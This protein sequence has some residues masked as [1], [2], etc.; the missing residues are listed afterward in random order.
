MSRMCLA[1]QTAV[2][3]F[4]KF[5]EK[6]RDFLHSFSKKKYMVCGAGPIGNKNKNNQITFLTVHT[7]FSLSLR[8]LSK[9]SFSFLFSFFFLKFF[10]LLFIKSLC[11]WGKS[12]SSYKTS[13]HLKI[14][15][16]SAMM[17]KA[18]Q[19]C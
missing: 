10:L 15:S 13:Y 9:E 12:H 8:Y 14:A 7:N 3:Q 1:F 5:S 16:H 17:Q 19:Q 4:K 11:L 2:C 18:F 6:K